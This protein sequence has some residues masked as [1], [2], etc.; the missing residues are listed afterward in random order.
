M[1]AVM[2]NNHSTGA[3]WSRLKHQFGSWRRDA[4]LHYELMSLDDWILRD[5]GLSRGDTKFRAS[6]L[7]RL[8]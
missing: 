3:P 8:L 1:E 7:F 2:K 4:R 5:I 6:K